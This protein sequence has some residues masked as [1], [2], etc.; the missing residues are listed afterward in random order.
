MPSLE[1]LHNASQRIARGVFFVTV[2]CCF[3]LILLVVAAHI[4][5]LDVWDDSYMFVRYADNILRHHAIAWNGGTPTYGLTSLLYL[6][7]VLVFRAILPL[8]PPM[9]LMT[10]SALFGILFLTLT[11]FA[12][13][14][15]IAQRG[16][17]R[18]II[19]ISILVP[20]A[21]SIKIFWIHF[22]NGMDTMFVLFYT[23]VYLLFFAL[24]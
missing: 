13:Y 22:L 7:P 11:F 8:D 4:H 6:L 21:L 9:L 16:V 23:T 3:S 24:D 19:I 14:T 17:E 10:I 5:V 18:Q 2:V 1:I 12:L 15:S 20:I